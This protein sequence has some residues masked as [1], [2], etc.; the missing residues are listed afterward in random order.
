MD[1]GTLVMALGTP[2]AG[3]MALWGVLRRNKTDLQA[4]TLEITLKGLN[5]RVNIL[6]RTV[7]KLEQANSDI[8]AERDV[9]RER[10]IQAESEN[11]ILLG[12]IRDKDE[13]LEDYRTLGYWVFQG[14]NP[15]IPSLSWR[16]R[17]EQMEHEKT[18]KRQREETTDDADDKE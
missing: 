8:T 12:Q 15:P 10:R 17:H 4:K 3:A 9:E 1:W 7:A 16:I 13:A 2:L 5:D 14:A 6:E 18:L 11:S